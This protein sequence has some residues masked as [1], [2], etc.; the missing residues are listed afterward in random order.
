M[1]GSTLALVR[2]K[3]KA[4]IDAS[5][6][7]GTAMDQNLNQ[8]I[9]T[10]LITL[11]AQYDWKCLADEWRTTVVAN[12]EYTA[13][14]TA[15]VNANQ[16]TIN[17]DRPLQVYVQYT[18]YWQPILFG[19]GPAEYNLVY[20]A[21]RLQP[22]LKWDYKQGDRSTMRTWPLGTPDQ[23]IMIRGQRNPVTL[24]TSLGGPFSDAALV[25]LDDL[26][27][28]YTIAAE[29][30]A[31]KN[32]PVASA[33]AQLATMRFNSLRSDEPTRDDGPVRFGKNYDVQRK[34]QP[35]KVIAAA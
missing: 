34:L 4:E 9:E 29:Q 24:R 21:N 5:M 18:S 2:A 23:P 12:S 14:P 17:F 30:C 3:L 25:E 27:I 20:G 11:C 1:I 28:V 10:K 7:V 31:I 15:D 32:S 26:L 19:I 35:I 8:L 13:F 6:S 33:K 16:F 22:V